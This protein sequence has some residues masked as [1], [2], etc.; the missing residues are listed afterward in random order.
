V[1]IILIEKYDIQFEVPKQANSTG[2]LWLGA[3]ARMQWVRTRAGFTG[4]RVCW[5][6]F[7][8]KIL[9]KNPCK[10]REIFWHKIKVVQNILFLHV[11]SISASELTPKGLSDGALVLAIF[12][13]LAM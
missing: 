8:Q 1:E 10:F 11:F 6:I 4:L 2:Q 9:K 7:G 12:E 5:S 3:C 13:V